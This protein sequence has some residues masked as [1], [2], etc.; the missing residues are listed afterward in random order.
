M[1]FTETTLQGAYIIDLEK[2]EDERGFYARGFCR[3]EFESMN[4]KSDIAQAN[5]IYTK[6]MATLRGLHLQ[7]PPY[8]ETK[9]VRCTKGSIFDVI[10][11]LRPGSV[12]YMKHFGIDLTADNF[13]MVYVPEGFAHGY[14][15]LENDT[16]VAYH[17]TE[18]YTPGF[19]K[20]IRWNDPAF[21]IEWPLQPQIISAK[22]KS[23]PDYVSGI[24]K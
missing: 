11:D 12:T 6:E 13:K 15:T 5:I 23:F 16:H 8:E 24:L 21:N 3:N 18:F 17:V 1:I 14:L 4:L 7:L 22:D 20:G 10:I 2:K 19:E 9:L